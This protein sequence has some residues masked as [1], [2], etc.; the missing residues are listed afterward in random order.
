M[1]AGR[2]VVRR[3]SM[4]CVC[5]STSQRPGPL[6]GGCHFG[7]SAA[8][9]RANRT[10]FWPQP[11]RPTPPAIPCPRGG[12]QPARGR[13]AGIS[14]PAVSIRGHRRSGG[15]V[16]KPRMK[17]HG[18]L[19][20]P[21]A[22]AHRRG[23]SRAD[24]R[25]TAPPSP[26]GAAPRRPG[27]RGRPLAGVPRADRCNGRIR[28][29]FRSRV[30]PRAASTPWLS[31]TWALVRFYSGYGASARL[32]WAGRGRRWEKLIF[33]GFSTM[34]RSRAKKIAWVRMHE[35]NQNC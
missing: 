27:A 28:G 15:A 4:R 11:A 22:W 21:A 14:W 16:S 35:V 31:T 9:I 13:G 1:D 19:T 33:G 8:N 26:R 32:L 6:F 24:R 25:A 3:R 23:S 29:P 30:A 20:H 2:R 17:P 7:S 18:P 34:S 5:V 12:S 10:R